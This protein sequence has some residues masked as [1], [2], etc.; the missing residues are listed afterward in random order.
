MR[1]H[2]FTLILVALVFACKQAPKGAI[3]VWTPY[4]ESEEIA[5]NANH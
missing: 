1:K 4:D 5:E 2:Y 3:P